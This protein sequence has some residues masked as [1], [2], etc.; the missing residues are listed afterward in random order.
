MTNEEFI[1]SISLEGEEWRDVAGFE[2]RYKVS[3]LGRIVT[4]G[5]R[6]DNPPRHTKPSVMKPYFTKK[7]YLQ[8]DL[9]S[10]THDSRIAKDCTD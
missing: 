6:I 3:S 2:G 1:K 5:H 10:G 8:V 9:S 7:G 4:L